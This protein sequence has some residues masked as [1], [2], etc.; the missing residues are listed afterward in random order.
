MTMSG[1][2][3]W[4]PSLEGIVRDIVHGVVV[5]DNSLFLRNTRLRYIESIKTRCGFAPT[6]D[7][8]CVSIALMEDVLCD[9]Y[10]EWMG[11][12]RWFQVYC[13]GSMRMGSEQARAYWRETIAKTPTHEFRL[14]DGCQIEI[15]LSNHW[16]APSCVCYSVW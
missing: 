9:S 14:N 4:T 12:G 2:A 5:Y 3:D 15:F 13:T 6:T 7:P 16:A 1:Y 11:H 10:M 8:Y